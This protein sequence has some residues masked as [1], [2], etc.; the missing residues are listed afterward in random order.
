[1][2]FAVFDVA[3]RKKMIELPGRQ[4][5]RRVR[6]VQKLWRDGGP[7]EVLNRIRRAAARQIAPI[8]PPSVVRL[9]DVLAA[10]LSGPKT[11]PTLPTDSKS[12]IVV[13]WVITPPA[14]G[15]GGHTTIFRLIEYLERSNY[16]CR[17]YIYDVHGYDAAYLR[18]HVRHL[19][20]KLIGPVADIAEGMADAHAV[21]ATSWQTAYPVYN[22]P[23]R[24][25]RFYL[26]Q[27]FEPWF[28]PSSTDAVLAENTY[29]MGFHAVTAGKFLATKLA[30][31]YGMPADAFEFGCDT[32]IYHVLEGPPRRHRVL[33]QAGC[34]ATRF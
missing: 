23:C 1:M 29:R 25:K 33:R 12:P 17:V 20:P 22:D 7:Q 14:P 24:G 15:S 8:S 10:D 19:F 31:E 34:A 30:A 13:N 11:W 28:Y 16:Q 26:V 6:Q 18:S 4:I 9:G 3:F 32:E 2:T 21:I 27:D 5:W